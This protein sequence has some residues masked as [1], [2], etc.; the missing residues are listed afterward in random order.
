M[1]KSVY[2]N[3]QTNELSF[4]DEADFSNPDFLAEMDVTEDQMDFGEIRFSPNLHISLE[5]QKYSIHK[6][7]DPTFNKNRVFQLLEKTRQ[8]KLGDRKDLPF[9]FDGREFDGDAKAKANIRDCFQ[10]L[11][12]IQSAP[13]V[14][15]IRWKAY[16]NGYYSFE[17]MQAFKTFYQTFLLFRF[18]FENKVNQDTFDLKDDLQSAQSLEEILA[19]E[20]ASKNIGDIQEEGE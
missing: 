18:Q 9:I 7:T 14:F 20:G 6:A 3:K 8:G 5:T 1:I 11:Q 17:D 12:I 10:A 13:G 19:I 2:Y 4:K 16:D 15:P